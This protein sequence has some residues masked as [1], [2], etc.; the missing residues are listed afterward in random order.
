MAPVPLEDEP[1]YTPLL[2]AI[3]HVAAAVYL[4]YKVG[5]GLYRSHQE[6]GPAQDTRHRISQRRKSIPVFASLAAVAFALA[7]SS[8]LTYRALSWRF[9]AHERGLIGSHGY[10][11]SYAHESHSSTKSGYYFAHWLSDTPIYLDALEIVAEKARRFWW[12]QQLD[13]ATVSWNMF[14]TLEGRR[15]NIPFLW[16]YPLL[17]QLVSLSFAMNLFYVAVLLT[18]STIPGR[19]SWQ[20]SRL[21][22]LWSR[23]FPPK[24]HN[25]RPKPLVFVL[26]LLLSYST[27]FQLPHAAGTTSF[28]AVAVAT[29]LASLSPLIL[30][31]VVPESWGTVHAHPHDASSA[32]KRIFQFM[33]VANVFLHGRTT[34]IGLRDNLPSSYRHRHTFK[35]PFDTE[36]RPTWERGATAFERILDSMSEHPAVAAAGRD[37]LLCALSLGL[38]AAFRAMDVR[39]MLQLMWPLSKAI[40]GS[41]QSV[42]APEVVETKVEESHVEDMPP[43]KPVTNGLSSVRRGRGRPAKSSRIGSISS[44]DGIADEHLSMMETPT[45][46][47]RGRP[48]KVKQEPEEVREEDSEEVPGDQTYEPSPAESASIVEGDVVPESDFDGESASVAWALTALAGLGASSTAVFGA[49]CVSR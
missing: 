11:N 25:W 9:W 4:T 8:G 29:K 39:D 47:G 31:S 48:R 16:A 13:L 28:P 12:G 26:P 5:R 33:F 7:V 40:S 37:V 34:A 18:P 32:Y 20:D 3:S 24:P 14:L 17:A 46:R 27:I 23:V 36:K 43:P 41:S 45:R 49:D 38:W 19:D 44:S 42:Q 35:I 15:R 10:A 22:R 6:L 21:G 1:R 2:L 30:H